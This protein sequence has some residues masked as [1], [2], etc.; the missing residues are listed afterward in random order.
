MIMT[1]PVVVQVSQATLPAGSCSRMASR[2]ASEIWS[3]ILSGCP[4]VTDSD[5]KKRFMKYTSLNLPHHDCKKRA[6]NTVPPNHLSDVPHLPAQRAAGLGTV[7]LTDGV[8]AASQDPFPPPLMIRLCLL[9]T[10]L[11]ELSS[12]AAKFAF[13]SS[14]RTVFTF[15]DPLSCRSSRQEV[16]PG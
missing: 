4:S 13:L 15:A 5:V 3:Q 12:T 8:A 2:T 7:R 9:Y 16:Y 1:I 14:D 6:A 11:Q 10:I